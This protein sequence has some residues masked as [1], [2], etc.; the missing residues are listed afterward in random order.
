MRQKSVLLFQRAQ[1]NASNKLEG[2]RCGSGSLTSESHHVIP[3][4][5][6]GRSVSVS[7]TPCGT[8]HCTVP[9]T[10]QITTGAMQ[11][12]LR[13]HEIKSFLSSLFLD[14]TKKMDDLIY[15]TAEA[16]N[17]SLKTDFTRTDVLFSC[18]VSKP[19]S[20]NSC[21]IRCLHLII[22]PTRRTNFSNL[23]LQ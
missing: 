10:S 21:V 6:A 20:S 2:P 15:R 1:F 3:G 16:Q 5:I 9:H 12:L 18:C 23:F 8:S 17:R 19:Y 14:V 13:H 22:K 7:S 4:S 11:S